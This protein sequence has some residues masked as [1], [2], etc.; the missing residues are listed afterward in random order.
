[1]KN[2]TH[3]ELLERS[4]KFYSVSRAYNCRRDLNAQVYSSIII[5]ELPVSLDEWKPKERNPKKKALQPIVQ[6]S[7]D[8]IQALQQLKFYDKLTLRARNT[9]SDSVRHHSR[10]HRY[11][12][13]AM[14][15]R[16]SH[17]LSEE[18]PRYAALSP[19]SAACQMQL[20]FA[21]YEEPS[22]L[23]DATAGEEERSGKKSPNATRRKSFLTKRVSIN[24]SS[25][26]NHPSNQSFRWK[27]TTQGSLVGNQNGRDKE[28]L[29]SAKRVSLSMREDRKSSAT[30]SLPHDS[31]SRA[32]NT[33][34]L[35]NAALFRLQEEKPFRISPMGYDSRY[36]D[37]IYDS[38]RGD[39]DAIAPEQTKQAIDKC[40][41]WLKKHHVDN[42][43]NLVNHH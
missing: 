43:S 24:K 10:H 7:Q 6:M 3:C 36:E 11:H 20:R 4:A 14:T 31:N 5:S 1:M 18:E 39:D 40:K 28:L 42:Y 19:A 34:S 17:A 8:A 22:L 2:R 23:E 33:M 29:T 35:R 32:A 38:Q 26:S 41:L 15:T 30:F 9:S 21:K 25:V 27:Q 12:Q 13:Q 37:L 16:S